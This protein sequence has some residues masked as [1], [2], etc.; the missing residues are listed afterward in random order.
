MIVREPCRTPR[1]PTEVRCLTVVL[2]RDNDALLAFS[3]VYFRSVVDRR[4]DSVGFLRNSP[5]DALSVRHTLNC[6][7][8]FFS[9]KNLGG[10]AGNYR[11][12]KGDQRLQQVF[13][14]A[15]DLLFSQTVFSLPNDVVRHPPLGTF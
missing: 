2:D 6:A 12:R 4:K 14:V 5:V 7:V 15:L 8:V 13:E 10:I 9:D 1:W 3:L 11:V